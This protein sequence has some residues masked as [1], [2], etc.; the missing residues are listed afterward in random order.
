[1]V[2]LVELTE[3]VVVATAASRDEVSIIV[4][5]DITLQSTA[6]QVG[7]FKPSAVE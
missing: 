7:L 6:A 5:R 3:G 4:L 2:A 1:M